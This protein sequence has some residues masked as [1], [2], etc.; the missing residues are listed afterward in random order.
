MNQRA[1]GFQGSTKKT[2]TRAKDAEFEYPQGQHASRSA[3]RQTDQEAGLVSPGAAAHLR[4]DGRRRKQEK[5]SAHGQKA[6][7]EQP[8]PAAVGH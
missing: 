6:A 4:V 3:Q 8:C 1:R 7:Q 5:G 2:H